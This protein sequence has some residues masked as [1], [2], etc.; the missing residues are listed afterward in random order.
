MVAQNEFSKAALR[1]LTKYLM[2]KEKIDVDVENRMVVDSE[3]EHTDPQEAE[4]VLPKCSCCKKPIQEYGYEIYDE[5]ICPDCIEG[6]R[7]EV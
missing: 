1:G 7:I 2:S 6:Y 5:L 3:W 4:E